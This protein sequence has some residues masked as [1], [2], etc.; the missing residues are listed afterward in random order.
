MSTRKRNHTFRSGRKTTGRAEPQGRLALGSGPQ[1]G[2]TRA[3][4]HVGCET[5]TG[6]EAILGMRVGCWRPPVYVNDGPV[7]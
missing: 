2:P 7:R 1:P 5:Q 6:I 4:Q 3:A